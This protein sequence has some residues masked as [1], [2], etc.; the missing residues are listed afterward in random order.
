MKKTWFII[1]L[2]LPIL[3]FSCK[4]E[5]NGKKNSKG[6]SATAY[7]L[8]ATEEVLM[9]SVDVA[10]KFNA[11][12]NAPSS[13]KDSIKNLYFPNYDIQENSRNPGVWEFLLDGRVISGV[14]TNDCSS[15]NNP[16]AC[17]IVGWD[18]LAY[19]STPFHTTYLNSCTSMISRLNNND[20]TWTIYFKPSW[21]EHPGFPWYTQM[22]LTL[23][24]NSVP[25]SLTG[26]DFTLS[27]EGA[28][29]FLAMR[30]PDKDVYYC[31]SFT[32]ENAQIQNF[33]GM[34]IHNL[35]T[36]GDL[37]LKV[38][39]DWDTIPEN[40]MEE[41]NLKALFYTKG[42]KQNA[43]IIMHDV[44]EEWTLPEPQNM[45]QHFHE[46]SFI[47]WFLPWF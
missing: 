29:H 27:G 35:W 14:N 42:G 20:N 28:Y 17:W 41:E 3:L 43:T 36:S 34:D 37:T 19:S 46:A 26:Q 22:E 44:E 38:I 33:K 1:V 47:E 4:V 11:W 2:I 8:D 24:D 21:V 6:A 23:P 16:N 5:N 13:E 45:E 31:Q 12:L 32:I 30:N 18:T 7:W 9:R 25:A 10:F 39:A 40:Y 15:L